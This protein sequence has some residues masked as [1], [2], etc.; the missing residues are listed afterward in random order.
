MWCVK[1]TVKNFE[2]ISRK[3]YCMKENKIVKRRSA[4]LLSAKE[5]ELER[6]S[7]IAASVVNGST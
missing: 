7:Y 4:I 3:G 2:N 1:Y 5:E 6:D